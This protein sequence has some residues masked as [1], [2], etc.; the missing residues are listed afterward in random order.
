MNNARRVDMSLKS[1][2]PTGQW[3]REGINGQWRLMFASD[4]KILGSF[5]LWEKVYVS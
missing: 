2:N 5:I 1:I 3:E 4:E